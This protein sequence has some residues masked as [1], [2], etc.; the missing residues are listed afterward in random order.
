MTQLKT[1][2]CCGLTKE[3]G[4]FYKRKDSPDGYRNDCKDCRIISSRSNFWK[5]REVRNRK[6]SERH[7]RKI[8]QN[9][10]FYSQYYLSKKEK[11]KV[12]AAES[13]QRN[14]D[15]IKVRVKKW[16]S[17]NRGKVNAISK[18]YKAAKLRACPAWVR[19]SSELRAQMD[20]IYEKAFQLSLDTGVSHHVDHIIPLR[21]KAVSGLHVPWNLQVLTG[22]ENCRKS[23]RIPEG[24]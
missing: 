12:W 4:E 13:Y 2:N 6:N 9:P 1:C 8:E 16:A 14:K 3:I 22:S 20:A 10:E 24:V 11:I 18:A 5:N 15:K 19:N 21:G 17:Q 23:N 7:R